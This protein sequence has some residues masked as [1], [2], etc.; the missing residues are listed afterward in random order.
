VRLVL[1]PLGPRSA[2]MTVAARP[3][4]VA[5]VPAGH[6]RFRLRRRAHKIA[7]T[8]HV[9]AAV[10]WFGI[11]VAIAFGGVA[12]TVTSDPT[13]AHALFRA[14]ETVPWLS[15]PFGLIAVASGMLLGVGTVYGLVRHW[16][17]VA[18]IAI[19][20]AVIITDSVIV[21][22]VAHDAAVTGSPAPPLF[23]STSAHVVVLGVATALSVFKP[24]GRTPW[25]RR[26][27]TRSGH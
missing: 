21:A 10:G 5:A 13:L 23:G 9:L 15:I 24:R 11:A 22:R 6:P 19:A 27:L 1:P 25:G 14:M 3:V 20:A 26:Q 8:A 18:K 7:I 2:T 12:A 4:R 17:V 16:W